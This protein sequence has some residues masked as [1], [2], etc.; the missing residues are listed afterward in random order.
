[1]KKQYDLDTLDCNNYQVDTWE[2]HYYLQ[3]GLR[4]LWRFSKE[5]GISFKGLCIDLLE[6]G[7]VLLNDD[8]ATQIS[9][10]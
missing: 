10:I 3:C 5:H 2:G 4:S 8:D 9:M 7:Y 1:M 6:K